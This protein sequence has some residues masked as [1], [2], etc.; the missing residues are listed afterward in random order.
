[1]KLLLHIKKVDRVEVMCWV[2]LVVAC[3]MPEVTL[4]AVGIPLVLAAHKAVN[5]LRL[6]QHGRQVRKHGQV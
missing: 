2:S 3:V 5:R 4:A 6:E 1:M